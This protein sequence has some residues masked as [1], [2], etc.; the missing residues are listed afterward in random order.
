MGR[1]KLR[2]AESPAFNID[3]TLANLNSV[4]KVPL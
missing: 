1:C 4:G 3:A 2:T